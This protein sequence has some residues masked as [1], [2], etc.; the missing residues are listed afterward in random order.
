MTETLIL[1]W[2]TLCLRPYVFVFLAVFLVAGITTMGWIRTLSFWAITWMVAFLCELSSTRNGF[3]FGLYHY[4]GS[5]VGQELYLWNVPFM[6]SLSFSF[7][8]F[9]S[10][11][12]ALFFVS[13]LYKAGWRSQYL[14]FF[15]LRWSKRVLWLSTLFMVMVDVVIDPVALRGDQ[16]FLGSIYHYEYH[17]Y[18]F[19]VPL[20][21]ALGWAF[22]GFVGLWIYQWVEKKFL[23]QTFVDRG[24]WNLPLKKFYGLGLY[25]GVLGF[26][27]GVSWWISEKA[28]LISGVF[29][30]LIPVALVINRF[31]DPRI[32]AHENDWKIYCEEFRLKIR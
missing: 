32:V 24:F 8:T 1:L 6:D 26:M 2:K 23:N 12:C 27:Y 13:P 29:I 15:S 31:F 7:L 19:G 30:F 28:L 3:P 14:D 10:Y 4:N 18:Y 11:S 22:V 5:T 21:N 17:G 9:A 20:S 16:W 25:G